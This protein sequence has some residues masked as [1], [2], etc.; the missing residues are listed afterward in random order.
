MLQRCLFTG[1]Y[2][3]R[4]FHG[5]TRGRLLT[6]GLVCDGASFR[7]I[8]HHGYDSFRRVSGNPASLPFRRGR[9]RVFRRW[10]DGLAGTGACASLPAGESTIGRSPANASAGRHDAGDDDPILP[11]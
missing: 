3:Q 9:G 7:V 10:R 4:E 6:F 5:G 11:G 1:I 2:G 8:G